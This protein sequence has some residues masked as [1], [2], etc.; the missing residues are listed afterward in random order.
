MKAKL[1]YQ[2]FW[3]I[4]IKSLEKFN[5]TETRRKITGKGIRGETKSA[6]LL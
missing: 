1:F 3:G 4:S 2:A 6:L 5:L